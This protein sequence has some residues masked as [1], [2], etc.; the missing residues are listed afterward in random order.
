M[1]KYLMLGPV[2]FEGF[3][4]PDNI[5]FGG[6]QRMAL[7]RLPGG[8]RVVDAMGRDDAAI[9]WSGT[10]SGS[11]ATLRA[12]LIDELRAEGL[13][14][15]LLWES[16]A[17][18]VMIQGFIANYEFTN[19]VPYQIACTVVADEAAV[20]AQ[21]TASLTTIIA[22]DLQAASVGTDVSAAQ[23][24]LVVPGGVTPGTAA[25][26]NTTSLMSGAQ[27]AVRGDLAQSNSALLQASDPAAA[28]EAA[29]SAA[30]YANALGFLG[31]AAVNLAGAIT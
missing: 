30:Q 26:G 5:V 11:N 19:W 12:R 31:R 2:L 13:P 14:L 9:V 10:F 8:A 15:P 16:F 20:F 22:A 6:A 18:L 7:H 17:Y 1:S 28:A 3:E 4:L 23:Q 29:G 21:A 25:Y 27:A 24:A